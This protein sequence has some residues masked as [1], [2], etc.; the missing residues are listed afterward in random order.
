MFNLPRIYFPLRRW[1][2]PVSPSQAAP[3]VQS[4][5]NR[6][7]GDHEAEGAS[8]SWNR[9]SRAEATSHPLGPAAQGREGWTA[10]GNRAEEEPSQDEAAAAQPLY[11]L[12]GGGAHLPEG[13]P[14]RCTLPSAYTSPPPLPPGLPPV[15]SLSEPLLQLLGLFSRVSQTS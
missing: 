10:T 6:N 9:H 8:E 11:I 3:R 15:L 13:S 7:C 12:A 5:L 1:Q 14:Q 4:R 2:G